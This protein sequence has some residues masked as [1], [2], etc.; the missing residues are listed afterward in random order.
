MAG[1]KGRSGPKPQNIIELCKECKRP[2]SGF[3]SKHPGGFCSIA[4]S[5]RAAHRE[6]GHGPAEPVA[7]DFCGTVKLIYPSKRMPHVFCDRACYVNWLRAGKQSR[8][9]K[10][11]APAKA[12]RRRATV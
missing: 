9:E 3:P 1:I 2:L 8:M 5:S 12:V 11:D 7:C 6:A 10:E 4:C